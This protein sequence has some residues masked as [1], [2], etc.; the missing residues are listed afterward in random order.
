M[1]KAK[2]KTRYVTPRVTGA[3]ALLLDLL[4]QSTRFNIQVDEI[5]NINS[6][7]P[8]SDSEPLYFEF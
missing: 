3:S 5:Q 1:K 2:K 8:S 4:C 7:A 6:V